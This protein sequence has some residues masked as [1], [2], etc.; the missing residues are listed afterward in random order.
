[1]L[2]DELLGQS[3]DLINYFGGLKGTSTGLSPETQAGLTSLALE[4]VPSQFDKQES[5]LATQLQRQ[6]PT[7][8]PMGGEFLRAYAPLEA[9]KEQTRSGLLRDVMLQNEAEKRR[10][11]DLNNQYALSALGQASSLGSNLYGQN[12]Q[13]NQF[14]ASQA[15]TREQNALNRQNQLDIANLERQGA[16]FGSILASGLLSSALSPNGGNLLGKGIDALAGI[17]GGS[18]S[19]TNPQLKAG[20]DILGGLGLGGSSVLSGAGG[21]GSLAGLSTLSTAPNLAGG[22]SALSGTGLL[23]SAAGTTT[24][25][26]LG[27]ALAGLAT[28]PITWA[29]A[30]ALGAGLL[31]KKS[32][33]HPT[34]DQWVQGA[35]NP[36]D[37]SMAALGQAEQSGQIS[38]EQATQLR[39]QNAQNYLQSLQ[40]FAGQG[41]KQKTVAR[42][43]LATFKQ[44]YGDPSAY[45]VTVAI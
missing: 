8:L 7:G 6:N 24:G 25:G 16:P 14:E 38:P 30:G 43:A 35:Q 44:Y 15:L 28:N 37:K 39:I 3:K 32:Q 13:Q 18:K 5:D 34:A 36:F 27:S 40:E 33:V 21:L 22:F 42:Q 20:L 10:T 4:S 2:Y 17:F 11:G 23:P 9:A 1:M 41:S 19:P 31:W 12:Q 45:G 29:A 26:G